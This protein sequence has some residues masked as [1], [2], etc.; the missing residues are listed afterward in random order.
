MIWIRI[1]IL[2]HSFFY[3]WYNTKKLKKWKVLWCF[4]LPCF[5]NDKGR[6]GQ[7]V[8]I[9]IHGNLLLYIK[10]LSMHIYTYTHANE[11]FIFLVWRI[12]WVFII[13]Y[14]IFTDSA[15][16]CF[17]G[18]VCHSMRSLI[19]EDS[20]CINTHAVMMMKIYVSN[21]FFPE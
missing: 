6:G 10:A 15:I 4:S 21:Y 14:S 5:G 1:W 16:H 17:Y 9:E 2:F 13:M 8:L 3:L 7:K 19:I 12:I 18:L 20:L 11:E